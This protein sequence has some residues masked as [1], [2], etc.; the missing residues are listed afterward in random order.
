MISIKFFPHF[1]FLSSVDS[2]VV[3]RLYSMQ[4]NFTSSEHKELESV[5]LVILTELMNND[6]QYTRFIT[7]PSFR[8]AISPP[9]ITVSR[10]IF[11]HI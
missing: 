5:K 6:L 3:F 4:I 8:K 10:N 2:P 11:Y 1:D 9:V 7:E